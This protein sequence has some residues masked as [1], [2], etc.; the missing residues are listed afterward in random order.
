VIACRELH[1]RRPVF[2]FCRSTSAPSTRLVR[3]DPSRARTAF[4]WPSLPA[5]RFRSRC[6]SNRDP[7]AGLR[8]R[9]RRSRS[10]PR[11][12]LP[13][14]RVIFATSA[15]LSPLMMPGPGARP[16]RA[17]A[18]L[19][20][21]ESG[22]TRAPGATL[23]G[24]PSRDHAG[25]TSR[26]HDDRGAWRDFG[27]FN[28]DRG[29]AAHA[30]LH[31]SRRRAAGDG[32]RRWAPSFLIAG[33]FLVPW[34]RF[35]NYPV[36]DLPRRRSAPERCRSGCCNISR[37]RPIRRSPRSSTLILA[38]TVILLFVSDPRPSGLHRMA[39]TSD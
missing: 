12:K 17:V 6:F 4:C 11:G 19:F 14:V 2:R 22:F 32:C 39:E 1:R 23:A 15:G 20:A 10:A 25:L 24:R 31:L 7:L 29:R 9:S 28:A 34:P 30:R 16:F 8:Q 26:G 37:R 5:C 27:I 18:G 35:D 33:I 3:Q 38:G 21:A 13:G 36:L